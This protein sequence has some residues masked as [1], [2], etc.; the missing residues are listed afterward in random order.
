MK[1]VVLHPLAQTELDE[2]CAYYEEKKAGLGLDLLAEAE[3][4]FQSIAK[5]PSAFGYYRATRFR[6]RVVNRFPYLV[7]YRERDDYVWVVAIAHAKRKPE[8]WMDRTEED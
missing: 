5:N 6:K 3:R 7:I 1:P 4:V 8:Y 2:A